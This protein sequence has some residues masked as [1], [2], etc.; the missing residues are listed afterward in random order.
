MIGSYIT[1]KITLWLFVSGLGKTLPH[2]GEVRCK[3]IDIMSEVGTPNDVRTPVLVDCSQDIR[4]LNP[5]DP[6]EVFVVFKK[7]GKCVF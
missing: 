4:W 6:T 2:T 1:C 5:Q 7:G 3:V